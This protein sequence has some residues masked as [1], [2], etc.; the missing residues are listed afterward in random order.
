[1]LPEFSASLLPLLTQPIWG[2]TSSHTKTFSIESQN[3]DV[4]TRY[5]SS[6]RSSAESN[7]QSLARLRR[8][9]H[10]TPKQHFQEHL[11]EHLE[12]LTPCPSH[13]PPAPA[14]HQS[15]WAHATLPGVGS[16][17]PTSTWKIPSQVVPAHAFPYPEERAGRLPPRAP[18]SG[19]VQGAQWWRAGNSSV[20]ISAERLLPW[21]VYIL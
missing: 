14:R 7:L 4:T 19:C 2:A 12:T 10:R 6:T 8:K 3:T 11:T 18:R 9:E 13:P 1:M 16:L 5:A 20:I 21:I 15:G 17:F